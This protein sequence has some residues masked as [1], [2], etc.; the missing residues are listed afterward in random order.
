[1]AGV[2][3]HPKYFR[4]I[5]FFNRIK[6][7]MMEKY[8]LFVLLL[9]MTACRNSPPSLD[10]ENSQKETAD[11]GLKQET[12][13]PTAFMKC[14]SVLLDFVEKHPTLHVSKWESRTKLTTWFR[15]EHYDNEILSE[16]DTNNP[17]NNLLVIDSKGTSN[18][19]L[20][21]FPSIEIDDFEFRG[22]FKDNSIIIFSY[23]SSPVGYTELYVIDANNSICYK[24][25]KMDEGMGL[26]SKIKK[27]DVASR[28]I[29]FIEH[30]ENVIKTIYLDTLHSYPNYLSPMSYE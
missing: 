25:E 5:L 12:V 13:S 28:Y 3:Y 16:C 2:K 15:Y 27:V 19:S 11:K 29:T 14:D 6:T 9:L 17:F 18:T 20:F 22:T 7:K 1:M 10:Q 30:N 8:F 24:T 26:I 21:I 4:G 23:Y